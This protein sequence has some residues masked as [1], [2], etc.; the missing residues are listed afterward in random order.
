[1][2]LHAMPVVSLDYYLPQLMMGVNDALCSI[3]YFDLFVHCT[4]SATMPSSWVLDGRFKNSRSKLKQLTHFS[5]HMDGFCVF[6]D[7]DCHLPP[8]LTCVSISVS[9]PAVGASKSVASLLDFIKQLADV[10]AFPDLEELH[11]QVWGIRCAESLLN[12]VADH[13]SDLRRLSIIAMPVEEQRDR[14]IDLIKHVA[15]SCSRLTSLQLSAE[16]MRLL[17][18]EY[19]GIHRHFYICFSFFFFE[20]FGIPL[21]NHLKTG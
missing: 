15:S 18:D 7:L 1:M 17:V 9:L 5:L 20:E 13:L 4:F 8:C 2:Y 21:A 16:M 11:V 12:H 19:G 6:D 10:N 3:R 14:L